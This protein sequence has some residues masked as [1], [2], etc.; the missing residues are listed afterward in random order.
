MRPVH[1]ARGKRCAYRFFFLEYLWFHQIQIILCIT[2]NI[3]TDRVKMASTR[4]I[5]TQF[6]SGMISHGRLKRICHQLINVV[7]FLLP[8]LISRRNICLAKFSFL[9]LPLR[10]WSVIVCYHMEIRPDVI[11]VLLYII[12]FLYRLSSW[13]FLWLHLRVRWIAFSHVT[14]TVIYHEPESTIHGET[15]LSQKR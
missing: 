6:Q 15:K 3:F 4:L 10:V 11:I 12:N 8:T 2:D 1:L 5:L 9:I 7:W 13:P 14:E